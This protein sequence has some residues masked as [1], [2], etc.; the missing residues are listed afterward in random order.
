[1]FGLFTSAIE[2]A[3]DIVSAPFDGKDITKRQIARLINDGMTIAAIA[4][5]FGVAED[6]VTE[7]IKD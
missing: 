5:M 3:L 1:M 7:F 6:V 4:T 2:N